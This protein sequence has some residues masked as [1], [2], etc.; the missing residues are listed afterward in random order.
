ME[1]ECLNCGVEMEEQYD[2]CSQECEEEWEECESYV[3]SE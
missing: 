2:F 1:N 3:F